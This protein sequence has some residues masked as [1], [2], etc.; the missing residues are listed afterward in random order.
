MK[1][2]ETILYDIEKL[3]GETVVGV[4][5][6]NRNKENELAKITDGENHRTK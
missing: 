5:P 2:L 3:F 1:F 6:V 4:G